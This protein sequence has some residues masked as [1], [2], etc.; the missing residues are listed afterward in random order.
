[1]FR[2]QTVICIIDQ[3]A[4][5]EVPLTCSLATHVES[6]W[7]KVSAEWWNRGEGER[8]KMGFTTASPYIQGGCFH[9]VFLF[10]W[11]CKRSN[12]G[13]IKNVSWW[14]RRS[15]VKRGLT[16]FKRS[17]DARGRVSGYFWSTDG[18]P[19][20]LSSWSPLWSPLWLNQSY[21]NVFPCF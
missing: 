18:K 11:D 9:S 15:A 21:F 16:L 12:G 13:E 1:M 7:I 14:W 5:L 2:V 20:S 19:G 3:E 6:L 10:W 17:P 8:W 4:L